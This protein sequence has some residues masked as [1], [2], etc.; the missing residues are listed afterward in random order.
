MSAYSPTKS[1]IHSSDAPCG[2][3]FLQKTSVATAALSAAL[4]FANCAAPII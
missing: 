4:S 1:A 2:G 3:M